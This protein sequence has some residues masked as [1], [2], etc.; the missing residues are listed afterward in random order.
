MLIIF[1]IIALMGLCALYKEI[2]FKNF[3][4]LAF[5]VVFLALCSLK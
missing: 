4:L 1:A 5:A 2:G 3:M